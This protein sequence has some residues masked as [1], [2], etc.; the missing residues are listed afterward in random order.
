MHDQGL[1]IIILLLATG[2]ILVGVLR[3]LQLPAVFAYLLTGVILGPHAL[4]V[5]P[6]LASTRQLAAFG[7]VFLMFSIGLEFSLSQFMSMRRLIFGMGAAQVLLT[8]VIF[9]GIALI[10]PL[11]WKT[12]VILGGILA[13]SSTAMVIRALAEKMEMQSRH[14]RIAVSVLLFQDLAVVP[15]LILIPA[16]AGSAKELPHDLAMAGLKAVVVLLVLLVIGRPIMRPW[17]QLIANRKSTELFMLNVLLVTLAL[18]WIT[19]QAGL[20]LALGAFVAGMLISETAYRYQVEADIAPFRDILLGLFF[21]TI[22]MLVDLPAWWANIAWVLIVLLLIVFLKGFLVWGLSRL[23]GYEPGVALRSAIV[24]AQAGEFGFVL[25]ALANQYQLLPAHVLQPVLGGMLLSMI[26]APILVERNGWIARKLVG[27][28]RNHRDQQLTEIRAADLKA[29]VVLCGYGRVG[30]SVGRVLEEEAIP[31]IALDLDPV[32]VRQAQSAGES[33][34]YGDAS[35]RDVLQAAGIFSARAV[36]ITYANVASSQRVLSIIKEL[37]PEL[38]VVVRAHDDSQL[39][40]LEAAGADEVVPEVN[41]GALMLASQTLLLIGF[42][43][44]TV[45]R[46]VRRFRQ[47]RYQFFRGAFWGG[48]EPGEDQASARL[49]SIPL[50]E[51]AF[52]LRLSLREL[53]LTSFGVSVVAVRRHGIRGRDPAPDTVLKSGDVLVLFGSP[54]AL[55]KAELYVLEGNTAQETAVSA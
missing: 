3:F 29:H 8:S 27:S 10:I 18:A 49:A 17:F 35:R 47:E 9:V 22:G 30:Q 40:K 51:T 43:I 34:F 28:Y 41:E 33:I 39:E 23:F 55:T 42:P 32:R 11:S 36:V 5:V 26:L 54:A 37:R 15:L 16:L 1:L 14:G 31:F 12:G 45:L 20:S 2:V 19:E 25:L 6:D 48:S 46:R 50:G 38:P 53:N 44:S 4:A 13:M 21:V 52:G 24:L 7:V